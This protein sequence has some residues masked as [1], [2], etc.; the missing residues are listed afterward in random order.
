MND[1]LKVIEENK[2][3]IISLASL[4]AS[5]VLAVYTKVSNGLLKKRIREAQDNGNYIICPHCKK[6]I[7]LKDVVHIYLP[8]GSIDD[9]LDGKAD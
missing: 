7:S 5:I 8:D 1:V 4:F 3:M 2:E 9:N 6:A